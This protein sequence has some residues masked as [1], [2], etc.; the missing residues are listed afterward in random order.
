MDARGQGV[1]VRRRNGDLVFNEDR[2]SV[3][4]G[5]NFVRW[6]LRSVLQQYECT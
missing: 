1:G 3:G 6:M 2:V 5:E 4:E